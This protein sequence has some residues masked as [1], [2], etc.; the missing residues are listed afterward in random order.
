MAVLLLSVTGA[1]AQT[2]RLTAQLGHAAEVTSATFSPDGRLVVTGDRNGKVRKWDVES[3]LSLG[4]MEGA[5]CSL[6]GM[7][8]SPD[9]EVLAGQ[10]AETHE[11]RASVVLWDARTGRIHHSHEAEDG[12]F[13][14][15]AFVD[16]GSNLL[17]GWRAGGVELLRTGD[18]EI[19]W[20][21]ADP[22]GTIVALRPGRDGR[23]V[24]AATE[25]GKLWT[26]DLP[27]GT[28]RVSRSLP[29]T[30]IPREA[31]S[32]DGTLVVHLRAD[33]TA[34]LQDLAS[35][36]VTAIARTEADPYLTDVVFAPDGRTVLIAGLDAGAGVW[37]TR[38]GECMTVLGPAGGEI[39]DAEFAPDGASLLTVDSREAPALRDAGTGVV[40]RRFEGRARDV[41]W[42]DVARDGDLVLTDG[43]SDEISIWSL[44]AGREVRR[45]S[46]FAADRVFIRSSFSPDGSAVL[47]SADTW[48]ATV[49]DLATG[50]QRATLGR[51]L[52]IPPPPNIGFPIPFP[53]EL[54]HAAF[55]PTGR[56]VITF[57]GEDLSLEGQAL[58]VWDVQTGVELRRGAPSPRSSIEAIAISP[59]E[60]VLAVGDYSGIGA[61]GV[62]WIWSSGQGE[63]EG[64]LHG[65]SG[66]ITGVGFSADGQSL[67]TASTDGTTR[68]WERETGTEVW[69]FDARDDSLDTLA[70]A[71]D[72]RLVASG[73]RGGIVR[74]L[75]ARTG[76]EIHRLAGHDGPIRC[77]AFSPDGRL[78]LSASTDGTVRV[79]DT[80]AGEE[81]CA[82]ISFLDGGWA[83]VD[84][85]GRY[86]SSGLGDAEGL[87]WVVGDQPIPVRQFKE[88]FYE[89]GLLVKIMRGEALRPVSGL[90]AVAIPPAV[91]LTAPPEG[92][93]RLT[94]D[95]SNQGGG[96]G[97]IQLFVNGKEVTA[98]A[99][100]AGVSRRTRQATISVDVADA[101]SLIP[102]EVN[103]V[104]VVPWNAEGYLAGR[105]AVV[106]FV[107]PGA[108]DTGA[109]E[110]WAIVG[111]V[112]DYDG[113]GIDLRYAAKDAAA[114][115][116]ALEVGARRL[117]GADRV[118]LSLLADADDPRARP[119]TAEN[120]RVAFEDARDARTRDVLVVYL[121]GH[122]ISLS[123]ED[124]SY[125]YLTAEARS[126]DPAALTDPAV[127]R[128]TAVTSDDLLGWF[129]QIPALKQ[130]LVL[131]TCAAGAAAAKLVE[132]RE[133]SADQIRAIERLRSRTGFHVLM[134][135]AS[136]RVSYEA[137][138]FGQGL[139][140]YALLEGMKGAALREE[141]YVDVSR[142]FQYAADRVPQLSRDIGGIQ[143]PLI[144]APQGT[145]FD[146]GQLTP[147]D[148]RAV[149]LP[150]A[151]LLLLRPRALDP[152]QGFDRLGL[153]SALRR[154]LLADT[155]R[156]SLGQVVF[157]DADEMPR[158]LRPVVLYRGEDSHLVV[159]VNL[160]RDGAK[161]NSFE[162]TGDAE[163]G[164]PVV[165][166]V[167]PLIVAAAA[168]QDL[169]GAVSPTSH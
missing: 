54:Q 97:R 46:G 34:I 18:G 110:I 145:S 157:V 65:H 35:D 150:A 30:T 99:R 135:C 75:S 101:A 151:K 93:T 63:M 68:R 80:L 108:A 104:R 112:S 17:I 6:D 137:S 126:T 130:V 134:G 73:S 11:A 60:S 39:L 147:E 111:G 5:G 22:R 29:A 115:A 119:P 51:K 98:D 43:E 123:S 154:A 67:Y 155:S 38:S 165:A 153:E 41:Q 40:V 55:S 20:S 133:V 56:H 121:A 166:V 45:L 7:V 1:R 71:P 149:P 27:S 8:F 86:D 76:E 102:G 144:A 2:P 105:G 90:D 28:S 164:E 85:E 24:L 57:T 66:R 132:K 161:V 42:L 9:G 136:D 3:G 103:E 156:L 61:G 94:V 12:H 168:S 158:A 4:P 19:L 15:V 146:V 109:P 32:A 143:S 36:A 107:A 95:L 70:V 49:V 114:F 83:V 148:R 88:R 78:L 120:F 72:G 139:L 142:L 50:E 79:W 117:F 25:S 163:G 96:I 37:D 162:V 140:T 53:P 13:P 52:P 167:V 82:L 10:C 69:R 84:P 59:D 125:A 106:S 87:H 91:E 152:D 116:T 127:R 31:L 48:T 169:T 16:G 44:E 159:T 14:H 129:K 74:V 23:S 124:A 21:S 141:V 77:C 62:V 64:S 47:A 81:R 122:G 138:Q 89:P 33:G 58:S 100:G 118:H 128:R 131:D 92:S 160:I 113:D 26:V